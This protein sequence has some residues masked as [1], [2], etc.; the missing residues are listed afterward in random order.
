MLGIIDVVEGSPGSTETIGAEEGIAAIMR[1]KLHPRE[2]SA[3]TKKSGGGAVEK[4]DAGCICEELAGRTEDA[5]AGMFAVRREE[6]CAVVE[7][8]RKEE[9]TDGNSF[10]YNVLIPS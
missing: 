10:E 8:M 9:G 4:P 6:D 1:G 5:A 7:S 3:D 2:G